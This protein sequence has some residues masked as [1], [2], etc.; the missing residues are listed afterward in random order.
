[1]AKKSTP[2]GGMVGNNQT[3]NAINDMTQPATGVT[4]GDVVKQPRPI[5]S[6]FEFQARGG[7]QNTINSKVQNFQKQMAYREQQKQFEKFLSGKQESAMAAY[8]EA[9]GKDQELKEWIPHPDLFYDES[10]GAFMPLKYAEAF[11][12]GYKEY[13]KNKT[14][15]AGQELQGKKLDQSIGYQNASLDQ[16]KQALGL[17]ERGV[18]AQEAGTLISASNSAESARKNQVKEDTDAT[19]FAEDSARKDRSS[20]LASVGKVVQAANGFDEEAKKVAVNE[21]KQNK[22]AAKDS[23]FKLMKHN[24]VKAGQDVSDEAINTAID[25]Q[26]ATDLQ[27]QY[28]SALGGKGYDPENPPSVGDPTTFNRT[29]GNALANRIAFYASTIRAKAPDGNNIP[30]ETIDTML[31]SASPELVI[32][33]IINLSKQKSIGK[34]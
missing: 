3:M 23:Q 21:Y 32:Q 17:Q 11:A 25:I 4:A 12:T 16:R 7:I 30:V 29:M 33:A 20:L 31:K 27:D 10:T 1:M 5:G 8:Q 13:Q 34:K 6:N 14:A 15:A 28:E 22:L 19:K 9:I 2:I 18:Q 24:A 26:E